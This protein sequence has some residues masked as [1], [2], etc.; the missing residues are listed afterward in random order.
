MHTIYDHS[1]D[2]FGNSHYEADVEKSYSSY[3][4]FERF[5]SDSVLE[6]SKVKPVF[7]DH[8]HFDITKSMQNETD[9]PSAESSVL[10]ISKLETL[11]DTTMKDFKDFIN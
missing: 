3:K 5:I 1:D 2:V 6:E 11:W 7:I 10:Q 9:L 8:K 4:S